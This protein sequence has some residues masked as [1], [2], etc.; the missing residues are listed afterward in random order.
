MGLPVPVMRQLD[1]RMLGRL[2]IGDDGACKACVRIIV[3]P[4]QSHAQG[5]TVKMQG[6]VQVGDAQH[7]VQYAHGVMAQS[8]W[9]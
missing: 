5:V 8:K 3:A 4:L 1:G 9:E 6:G 7:G 2:A